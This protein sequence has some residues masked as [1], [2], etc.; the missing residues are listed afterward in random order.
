MGQNGNGTGGRPSRTDLI[1]RSV[2]A[3]LERARASIDAAPAMTSLQVV[4]Q[5]DEARD[6]PR[7]TSIRPEVCWDFRR[8][9]DRDTPTE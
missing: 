8:S 6:Q 9:P 5:F 4:V 7:K 1:L 3:S 2:I